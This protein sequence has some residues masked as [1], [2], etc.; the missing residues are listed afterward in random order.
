M[1]SK[2]AEK[3]LAILYTASLVF[4]VTSVISL[5]VTWQNWVLTLDGCLDVDCGCILY[6]INTFQTFLGGDEKLCHFAAYCL[7]PIILISLCLSAYHGYRCCIHKN[8]DEPK[9]IKRGQIYDDDRCLF[10]SI[11]HL[12]KLLKLFCSK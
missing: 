9:Q 12:C 6:G 11:Y 1:N 4:S 10:F 7:V 2:Q 5:V 8:L 3:W